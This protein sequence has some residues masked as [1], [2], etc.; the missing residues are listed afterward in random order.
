MG[1]LSHNFKKVKESKTTQV[2]HDKKY[3]QR[4]KEQKKR[5]LRRIQDKALNKI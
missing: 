3:K 1:M 5:R 2:V 4:Y